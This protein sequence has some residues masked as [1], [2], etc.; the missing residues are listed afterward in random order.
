MPDVQAAIA[1]LRDA[2]ATHWVEGAHEAL[3]TVEQALTDKDARH[4]RLKAA[5][6]AAEKIMRDQDYALAEERALNMNHEGAIARLTSELGEAKR[7]WKMA[8]EGYEFSAGVLRA[9]LETNARLRDA[10]RGLSTAVKHFVEF[11]PEWNVGG[12][13]SDESTAAWKRIEEILDANLDAARA[14]LG[15][16]E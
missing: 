11:E 5:C 15:E 13:W 10:L 4:E 12:E 3:D 6:R 14:A 8:Q 7:N 1:T 16:G 2:Q 9:E